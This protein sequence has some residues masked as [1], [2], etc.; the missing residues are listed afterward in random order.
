MIK[1][2]EA[3]RLNISAKKRGSG[4]LIFTCSRSLSIVFSVLIYYFFSASVSST[5]ADVLLPQLASGEAINRLEIAGADLWILGKRN[6]YRLGD[7]GKPTLV[8]ADVRATSVI[9]FEGNTYVGTTNGL[10]RLGA[11]EPEFGHARVT[12]LAVFEER[13][14]IGTQRGLWVLGGEQPRHRLQVFDL[15]AIGADL[16]VA[17]GQG[18]FRIT[19]GRPDFVRLK[20][21]EFIG[22][23]NIEVVGIGA[24]KGRPSPGPAL[25]PPSK[26][27]E[28]SGE[29]IWITTIDNSRFDWPGEAYLMSNNRA[30]VPSGTSDWRVS[31]VSEYEGSPVFATN[32]GLGRL[33]GGKA[34]LVPTDHPVR[35]AFVRDS[36]LWLATTQGLLRGTGPGFD[37]EKS[38]VGGNLSATD[39]VVFQED[40]WIAADQGL[41]RWV[42]DSKIQVT[43]KGASVQFQR[44]LELDI[45]YSAS[46][47]ES[48]DQPKNTFHVCVY[49]DENAQI[50]HS[51]YECGN[52]LN[53]EPWHN[54]NTFFARD[55][56]GNRSQ[57]FRYNVWVFPELEISLFLLVLLAGAPVVFSW[58]LKAHR[59]KL[60]AA[61]KA[62]ENLQAQLADAEVDQLTGLLTRS[63]AEKKIEAALME[64]TKSRYKPSLLL[65]DIDYFKSINDEHG[66]NAGDR[67][68]QQLGSLIK[69]RYRRKSDHAVRWGG[70]EIVVLS[71]ERAQG[72]ALE[73]AEGLLKDVEETPVLVETEHGRQEIRMT[74]SVGIT[75]VFHPDESLEEV[76]KRIDLALYKSKKSGRNR[77]TVAD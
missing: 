3:T 13:L 12:S 7:D 48:F 24:T 77:V 16:W 50:K 51:D 59:A 29:S 69:E 67:A 73:Y 22:W 9:D 53:L 63:S 33:N 70:D 26:S 40:L 19:A 44:V 27:I 10:L 75:H 30:E 66:H 25:A 74:I 46:P 23:D 21:V 4:P 55:E 72:L 14:W 65:L 17:S 2:P 57:D 58:R 1:F 54:S 37:F 76:F 71:M 8:L 5:R 39:A 43:V 68:L 31:S 41:F 56:Y 18:A 34:E 32:R 20:S 42:S 64:A 6:L 28:R 49:K 35:F 52:V 62:L 60:N 36:V 38:P 15:E 11:A 45:E 61:K 47:S